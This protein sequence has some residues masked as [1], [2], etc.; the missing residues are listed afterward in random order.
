VL[1]F[2]WLDVIY[3]ALEVYEGRQAHTLRLEFQPHVP[4]LKRQPFGGI[5]LLL[6]SS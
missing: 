3:A 5:D 6:P 4:V 2:D 1:S